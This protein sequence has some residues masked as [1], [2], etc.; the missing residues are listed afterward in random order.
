MS[1]TEVN[2]LSISLKQYFY[3]LKAHTDLVNRLIIT[4]LLAL[5]FSLGGVSS[6]SSGSANLTVSLRSYSANI[7]II[8]S[9]LWILITAI[10]LTTKPY[11]KMEMPL[12]G[13]RI[14]GDISDVGFL[15]TASVFA[16]VTSSLAGVLLRVIMYFTFDRS[17]MG[18]D[19][20]S[21]TFSD[22]LLGM[23]VAILYLGLISAV[24]YFIGMLTQ[25]NMA[26]I[27]LIPAVIYGTLRV[28][29]GLAQSVFEFY[30]VDVSLPLF[31]LRVIITSIML[32]GVSMLLSNRMEAGK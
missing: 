16:G 18:F 14:S 9:I 20:F 22:L 8:F 32:F 1:S 21:L 2:L 25:M 5:L 6:M 15:M 24:G 3:K 31:A 7:V 30:V 11:K 29:T 4:Q 19:S 28:Y 12:V 26:F 13:N 27:V 10:L 17:K 23:L